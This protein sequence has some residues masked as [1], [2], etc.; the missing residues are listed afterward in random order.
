MVKSVLMS[1][2]FFKQDVEMRFV[3]IGHYGSK[4]NLRFMPFGSV[5]IFALPFKRLVPEHE[6]FS[7]NECI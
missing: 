4:E 6:N 1:D 2:I 7:R 5:L 3:Y